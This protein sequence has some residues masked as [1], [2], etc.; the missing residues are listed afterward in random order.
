MRSQLQTFI[1]LTVLVALVGGVTF[2]RNWTTTKT[3]DTEAASEKV[4][5]DT[6]GNAAK[7]PAKTP[8]NDTRVN[9]PGPVVNDGR[10]SSYP[11]F[12]FHGETHFDF[13]F[14]SPYG[15]AIDLGLRSKS[16]KCSKIEAIPL[17][18]EEV[19][20]IREQLPASLAGQV[21][22]ASAGI[23]PF[24]GS[25]AA[26]NATSG[27]VLGMKDR[28][29]TLLPGEDN[30]VLVPPNG[31]GF[32]RINVEG[33][34]KG[35]LRLVIKVWAQSHGSTL[36]R[37]PDLSMDVPVVVV[38]PLRVT[39]EAQTVAF[40]T[41][42]SKSETEFFCWSSTRAGFSLKAIEQSHD[43]C[44]ECEV[45][46]L[47]GSEFRRIAEWLHKDVVQLYTTPLT[48]YRVHVTVHERVSGKQMDLGPFFREIV[49]QSDQPDCDPLAVTVQGIVRGDIDLGTG[50]DRDQIKLQ[51]F[52]SSKGTQAS[53]P[54][55]VR[56]PGVRLELESVSPSFVIAKLVEKPPEG[57]GNYELQLEIPPNRATG[58]LPKE[59][60]VFLKT[61]T[62]PPRRVR[63]PI[64]G[65]ATL[66]LDAR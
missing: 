66:G 19:K 24:L 56:Q 38:Q 62:D 48:I 22:M 23:M 30:G 20:V 46:S 28:W 11:E 27:R 7:E 63:I 18:A 13:W 34:A 39:P 16:C 32:V 33:R 37:G 64:I 4:L 12:E 1:F 45:E 2:L 25:A 42:N 21:A 6:T 3:T 41:P 65:Q 51:S 29:F 47:T 50:E 55:R 59:S 57:A 60:A 17:S 43:P 53:F 52:A 8:D 54:I 36:T 61:L 5:V 26:T 44:L 10:L 58:K 14:D 40:L 9:I 49:L 31:G 35:P 15:Q